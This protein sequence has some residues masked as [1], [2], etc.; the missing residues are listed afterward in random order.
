MQTTGNIIKVNAGI[1]L[2]IIFWQ[3]SIEKW[4]DIESTYHENFIFP[5]ACLEPKI[6]HDT[7]SIPYHCSLRPEESV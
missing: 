6:G 7:A 4:L 3:K 2:G 1:F 5:M